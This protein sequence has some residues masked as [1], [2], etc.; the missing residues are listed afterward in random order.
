MLCANDYTKE[1]IVAC[2]LLR[3]MNI[4]GALLLACT[5]GLLAPPLAAE[6]QQSGRIYRIG[7]LSMPA[8]PSPRSEALQKGLADLG[9]EE[10]RSI[11]IEWKWAAGS[12]ERL[13]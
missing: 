5:L 8:G 12:T 11:A 6:A 4:L 9:Y 13:P 7:V 2:P 1:Y 3:A 10:G